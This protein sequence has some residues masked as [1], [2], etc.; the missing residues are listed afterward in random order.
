ILM[1]FMVRL[2]CIAVSGLYSI[3]HFRQANDL[4]L[5]LTKALV[6]ML[7]VQEFLQNR[8]DKILFFKVSRQGG[9][10]SNV[11]P[12]PAGNNGQLSL[13]DLPAQF[14]SMFRS[15]DIFVPN[16][17]QSRCLYSFDLLVRKVCKLYHALCI[18]VM[19]YL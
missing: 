1:I 14:Q 13:R 18:L 19:H 8:D 7:F 6:S 4:G 3:N 17:D 10:L 5:T 16:N 15:D 9:N 12:V 2:F 11:F